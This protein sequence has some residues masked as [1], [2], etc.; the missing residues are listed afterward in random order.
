MTNVHGRNYGTHIVGMDGR[1]LCK[2]YV[3]SDVNCVGAGEQDQASCKPCQWVFAAKPS[4][5]DPRME[6]LHDDSPQDEGDA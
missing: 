4:D 1:T 2:R 5:D 6:D 3:Q